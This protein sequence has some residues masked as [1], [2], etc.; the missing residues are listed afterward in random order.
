MHTSSTARVLFVPYEKPPSKATA[1]RRALRQLDQAGLING[2]HIYSLHRRILE[3]GR[4]A[5][6]RGLR[7]AIAQFQP[8][9]L[10]LYHPVGTGLDERDYR[11]LRS[12]ASFRLAYYEVDPFHWLRNPF[13]REARAA[14]RASDVVYTSGASTM[15]A[16]F[17]R[18]GAPEVRWMPQS[19]DPHATRI[20]RRNTPPETDIVMIANNGASRNPVRGHPGAHTRRRLVE[21]L[22]RRFGDR[23]RIY[24]R[25]WT[26]PSAAGILPFSEQ[27]RALNDAILSVNWDHYPKEA[28]YFSNRLP[29]SLAFGSVHFTTWHPGYDQIFPQDLDFLQ[30]GRTPEE[31]ADRADAFLADYRPERRSALADQASSFAHERF[32]RDDAIGRIIRETGFTLDLDAQREAWALDVDPFPDFSSASDDNRP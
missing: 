31:L 17:R 14:A 10:L 27:G 5:A 1:S 12:L 15:A 24:G 6:I 16:A 21:I 4:K 9:L 19:F 30:F 32:R 13:P 11:D 3:K 29:I 28:K 20:M 18:F 8:N 26:G 22:T 23:F 7:E 25:G 2:V